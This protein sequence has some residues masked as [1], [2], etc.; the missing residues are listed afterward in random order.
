VLE[1]LFKHEVT[2]A[3]AVGGII[4]ALTQNL[5]FL[6][7]SAFGTWWIIGKFNAIS[8]RN[9]ENREKENVANEWNKL[10]EECLEYSSAGQ[11]KLKPD[12]VTEKVQ[13]L[14]LMQRDRVTSVEIDERVGRSL[15]QHIEFLEF[16]F[17]IR[18][19]ER[20]L[21]KRKQQVSHIEGRAEELGYRT[22][23]V[24]NNGGAV[25]TLLPEE[26]MRLAEREEEKLLFEYVQNLP[27]I[28]KVEADSTIKSPSGDNQF[29]A[30]FIVTNTLGE[31]YI[32]E[33][34]TVRGSI[35][36]AEKM[37]KEQLIRYGAKIRGFH[38]M[39]QRGGR[40]KIVYVGKMP[41][42][43]EE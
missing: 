32:I 42:T 27:N 43:E 7:L 39:H 16:T 23:K 12:E 18:L 5:P 22:S 37:A 30:D 25:I 41:S 17:G 3:T 19:K 31:R 9:K 11:A 4:F 2:I 15:E 14:A 34:K 21:E 40:K 13:L 35:P 36:L 38:V 1:T 8:L 26:K 6:L 33:L 20:R 24:E 28:V 10:L 29:R